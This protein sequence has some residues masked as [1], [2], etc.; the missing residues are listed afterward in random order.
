MKK[1]IKMKAELMG[2]MGM[3]AGLQAATVAYDFDSGLSGV[4]DGSLT[5]GDITFTHGL[6]SE[7]SAGRNFQRVW[8]SENPSLNDQLFISSRSSDNKGVALPNLDMTLEAPSYTSFSLTPALGQNLDFSSSILSLRA[9]LFND[10]TVNFNMGYQIWADTGSGWVSLGALQTLNSDSTGNGSGTI[11]E[12]DEASVLTL[13]NSMDTGAI[14]AKSAVL[15][16][17]LSALGALPVDQPVALAVA[18]S[19]DRD[20]HASFGSGMDDIAV[21]L[22]EGGGGNTQ[23]VSTDDTYGVLEEGVLS[24]SAPGV[25]S[26][27][28]DVNDDSLTAQWLSDPSNGSL[29]LNTNG[30]F[31]YTPNPDFFGTDSFTYQAHDGTAAG[32]V[33]TASITVTN[34]PDAPVAAAD[35]YAAVSGTSLNVTAPGVLENDADADG[36]SLTAIKVSDPAHGSVVV[37][38]TGAFVYTPDSGYLGS[39]SF[40][41]KVNDGLAD[42]GTVSV[43]ITVSEPVANAKPNILILFADDMGYGDTQAYNPN[44]PVDMPRIEQLAQEGMRF[45]DAHTP[46]A[47]CAPNRYSILSGNYPWRGRTFGGSWHFNRGSQFTA[48][49]ESMGTMLKRAGYHTAIIGKMHIGALVQPLGG[50]TDYDRRDPSYNPGKGQTVDDAFDPAGADWSVPLIDG[51]ASKG[52]DYSF[53][54]YSGIQGSPYMFFENDMVY[55]NPDD[56]MT[57]TGGS[58]PDTNGTSVIQGWECGMG[59]PTWKT[60]EVGPALVQKTIA[61]IDQHHRDN[62]ATGTNTPFLINY[63]A[64]AVHVPHTPPNSFLGIPVGGTTQVDSY[65]G[66]G[67]SEHS[68]ML[69]ELDVALGMILDALDARGLLENTLI[70]LTSDNGGLPN[71]TTHT[72]FSNEPLN[73]Y[74]ST[75]AEGGHR[76]PFIVKWGDGTAAGSHIPP[77]SVAD[78]MVNIMDIYTT[79]AE[80]AGVEVPAN[81]ALDSI[82]MREI[83]LEGSTDETRPTMLGFGGGSFYLR[84]GDWKYTVEGDYA[85]LYHLGDDLGEATDVSSANSARISDMQVELDALTALE[86]TTSRSTAAPSP[87]PDP[88]VQTDLDGDGMEDGWERNYFSSIHGYN[89]GALDDMDQDGVENLLEYALGGHPTAGAEARS[90]FPT[91]GNSPSGMAYIY[92]RRTN[93]ATLNLQ[94]TVE[95]TDSLVS[96]VWST[97]EYVEAESEDLGNGLESVTTRSVIEKDIEFIRL[98]IEGP[99]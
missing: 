83:W 69:Y 2:L 18:L 60:H 16:F 6:N 77:G 94:Y 4:S 81:Q 96:N 64:E 52:F 9:V 87:V 36:D 91:L 92:N 39:D 35:H 8:S 38:S 53:T 3:A 50:G 20:N 85:G 90:I 58:Y 95:Y 55:G 66:T 75:A 14:A 48:G 97:G 29:T 44:C 74:K 51:V 88:A 23:P 68:D 54:T 82:S 89:G 30:S 46:A 17:D 73:G 93:A 56:F 59:L 57:W 40:E 15:N 33:A 37:A 42:G 31:V 5:V 70:I 99:D 26:N 84:D 32:A 63:F 1:Q 13:G 11:Y 43:S 86:G 28:T 7:V 19:G 72:T 34:T 22:A 27:D 78:Q 47:L 25:L 10:G 76:V 79:L 24:V 67:Y 80:I 49:Q 12:V 41:Y 45:T 71:N 65:D 62:Q 61:F 98:K 21:T